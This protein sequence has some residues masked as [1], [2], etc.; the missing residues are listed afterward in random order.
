METILYHGAAQGCAFGVIV[1]LEWLC[2]PYRLV[3]VE[4]PGLPLPVLQSGTRLQRDCRAIL[5]HIG[6]QRRYL[7]GYRAGTAEARKLDALLE[8][9][10]EG[11]ENG[12]E[13]ME[14]TCAALD[15][16]LAGQEWLDGNKRTVA[17]ACLVAV[18]RWGQQQ[19]GLALEKWPRLERH[20]RELHGDP[21]VLFADAIE[22][23]R[24]AVSSGRFRGHLTP[25]AVDW[26]LAA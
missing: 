7:L 3:Q 1:A 24:P 5:R 6:C 26:P 19:M 10:H 18:L 21:A 17:D 11:F 4:L 12:R 20:A 2:R 8:Y 23:R 13:R 14:Q 16:A 22:T 25:D 9:L 15:E